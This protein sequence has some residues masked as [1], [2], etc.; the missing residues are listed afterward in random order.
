MRASDEAFVGLLVKIEDIVILHILRDHERVT[1][2]E[3]RDVEE[4]VIFLILCHL[5]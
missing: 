1:L 2:G 4:S 5:V 3:R